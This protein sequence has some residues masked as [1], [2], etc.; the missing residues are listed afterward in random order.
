MAWDERV[1][2]RSYNLEIRDMCTSPIK[3]VSLLQY[4]REK[5]AC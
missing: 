2:D 1:F 4:L 3:N 5:L